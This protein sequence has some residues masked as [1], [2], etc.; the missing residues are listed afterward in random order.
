MT[1]HGRVRLAAELEQRPDRRR[2]LVSLIIVEEVRYC[3]R[4]SWEIER[5]IAVD[6]DHLPTDLAPVARAWI[7]AVLPHL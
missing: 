2:D 4:W 3:V 6:L 7:D 1:A 5:V